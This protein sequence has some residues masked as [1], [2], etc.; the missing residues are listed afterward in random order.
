[1]SEVILAK[2][3]FGAL[4]SDLENGLGVKGKKLSDKASKS[5]Y[6]HVSLRI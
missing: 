1:M 2:D 5:L 4:D 6:S 3:W